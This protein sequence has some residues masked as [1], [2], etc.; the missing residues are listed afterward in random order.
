MTSIFSVEAV[1]IQWINVVLANQHLRTKDLQQ[2]LETI[3]T[4]L[5]MVPLRTA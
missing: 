4:V 5:Q 3:N 1:N 2:K